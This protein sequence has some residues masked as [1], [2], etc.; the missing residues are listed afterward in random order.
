MTAGK[1]LNGKNVPML[2]SR[3]A[4]YL[5][6]L[7][8]IYLPILEFVGYFISRYKACSSVSVT[9]PLPCNKLAVNVGA[10]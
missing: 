6:N 2:M 3:L 1:F 9:D 7:L 5:R 10:I 4:K 8:F